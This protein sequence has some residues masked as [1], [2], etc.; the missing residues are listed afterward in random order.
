MFWVPDDNDVDQVFTHLTN[1]GLIFC[2]SGGFNDVNEKP[3]EGRVWLPA[4]Q[5]QTLV[6][7]YR[8]RTGCNGPTLW[9][10]P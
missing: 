8:K 7:Q 10:I 3:E 5:E 4:A 1:A 6:Y 2:A 9:F